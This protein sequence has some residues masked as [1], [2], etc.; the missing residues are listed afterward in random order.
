LTLARLGPDSAALAEAMA[1]GAN[2]TVLERPMRVAALVTAVRS[3]LRGRGRQY[4][5][6]DLLAGLQE[7]DLR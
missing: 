3:A 6:R 2:L 4:E 5:L 1:L 7:A